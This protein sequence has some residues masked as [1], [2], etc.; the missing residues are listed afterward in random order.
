MSNDS[1]T[2]R[3]KLLGDLLAF[4][5]EAVDELMRP[6][7]LFDEGT[8]ELVAKYGDATKVPITAMSENDKATEGYNLVPEVIIETMSKLRD[9]LIRNLGPTGMQ[10]SFAD[11]GLLARS[12]D[13]DGPMHIVKADRFLYPQYDGRVTEWSESDSV[14][15]W[16]AQQAQEMLLEHKPMRSKEVTDRL[17]ALAVSPKDVEIRL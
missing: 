5:T 2:S 15:Q 7:D 9:I 13:F 16:V 10:M 12:I 14:R 4:V 17:E 6:S 11:T 3:D 8:A 1:L